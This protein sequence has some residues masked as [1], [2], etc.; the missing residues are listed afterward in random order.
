MEARALVSVV[1][2]IVLGFVVLGLVFQ[3]FE[4]VVFGCLVALGGSLAAILGC[5]SGVQGRRSH[6]ERHAKRG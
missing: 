6:C 1:L 5:G 4:V 3:R 2:G